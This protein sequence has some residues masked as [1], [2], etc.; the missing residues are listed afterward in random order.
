[1][2]LNQEKVIEKFIQMMHV[3]DRFHE[4]QIPEDVKACI[5]AKTPAF[6]G[7]SIRGRLWALAT[8]LQQPK[9]CKTC[10][11]QTKFV[12]GNRKWQFNDFCSTACRNKFCPVDVPFVSLLELGNQLKDWPSQQL[13]TLPLRNPLL[14]GALVGATQ[15]CAPTNKSNDKLGVTI[16]QRVWHAINNRVDTP[17][18][19]E[20]GNTTKWDPKYVT[21][22]RYCCP[23][24]AN[25]SWEQTVRKS[26]TMTKEVRDKLANKEWFYD[27][28]ITQKKSFQQIRA[29]NGVAIA[30]TM[31]YWAKKHNIKNQQYSMSSHQRI[32]VEWLENQGIQMLVN[33]RQ[34]ITPQEL[35]IVLPEYLIAIEYGSDYYHS[36]GDIPHLKRITTNYHLNKWKKCRTAGFTLLTLFDVTDDIE[37][38][39]RQIVLAITKTDVPEN[40]GNLRYY[41]SSHESTRNI[42]PPKIINTRT[43]AVVGK[44][45][46][47][48]LNLYDCGTAA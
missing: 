21:Y 44:S 29:E 26:K 2:Q 35:D 15:F 11:M 5:I 17:C 12:S 48:E 39:K 34:I 20:C 4:S 28:H 10:G 47:V 30:Y 16:M 27:Q 46:R 18:C 25:S 19:V 31:S 42:L 37:Q 32:L 23:E 33:N 7:F 43:I 38:C 3:R 40:K 41:H 8:D 1:M 14:Y 13:R 24:C 36:M 6:V 9:T 22:C 45:D